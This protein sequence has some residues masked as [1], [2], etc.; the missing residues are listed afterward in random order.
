MPDT[1]AACSTGEC[2]TLVEVIVDPTKLASYGLRPDMLIAGFAANNQLVAA[3]A[4]EGAEGRYAIKVPSLLETVEDVAKLPVVASDTAVVR[5]MDLAEIRPTLKDPETITRLI[6]LG[7]DP[8]SFSDS[9]LAV[10]AQRLVRRLCSL[11]R[12]PLEPESHARV[13]CGFASGVEV[14]RAAGGEFIAHQDLSVAVILDEY[15]SL[16]HDFFDDGD[17]KFANALLQNVGRDL[18]A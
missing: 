6:D 18:R 5:A 9:I 10:M 17:A 15:V 1:A 12:K 16:E 3:G 7:L 2:T 13:A 14:F 11:C 8:F 4:L